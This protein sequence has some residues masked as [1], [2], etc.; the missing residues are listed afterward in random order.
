MLLVLLSLNKNREPYF[1]A[2]V[3]RPFDVY[4]NLNTTQQGTRMG[5]N[6]QE[7]A[8]MDKNGQEWTRMDKNGQEWTRIDKNRQ[9][10]T[11][12]DKKGTTNL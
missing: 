7:W 11:R 9:E 5:K 2:K 4:T 6:G 3:N 10:W 12:K 1:F 8:R